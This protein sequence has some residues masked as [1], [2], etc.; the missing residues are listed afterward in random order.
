MLGVRRA[1][2]TEAIQALE[3][4]PLIKTDRGLISVIDRNR[5]EHLAGGLYGAPER[6]YERSQA[7]RFGRSLRKAFKR[8][9]PSR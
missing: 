3:Q 4:K 8:P 5:L 1:G 9:K 2:V 6:E 7:V